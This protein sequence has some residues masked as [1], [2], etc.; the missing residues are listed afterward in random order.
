[1]KAC[2]NIIVIFIALIATSYLG[3]SMAF[4]VQTEDLRVKLNGCRELVKQH[5]EVR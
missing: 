5:E 2:L 4:I 3:A 1:M